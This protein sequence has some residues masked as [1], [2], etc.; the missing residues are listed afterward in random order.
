MPLAGMALSGSE[1]CG[2]HGHSLVLMFARTCAG[3]PIQYEAEKRVE[4]K[5]QCEDPL[6]LQR[7]RLC[8][9]EG[10]PMRRTK[11]GGGDAHSCISP[12]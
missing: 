5:Y 10:K 9:A 2:E 11:S 7:K 4:V 12:G 1:L 3:R 6:G 8:T